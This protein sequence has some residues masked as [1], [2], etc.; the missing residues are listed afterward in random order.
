MTLDLPTLLIVAVFILAIAASLLL[1]TWLQN[2]SVRALALWATSFA[3][4]AIGVGLFV[5]RGRISDISSILIG[6]AFLAASYGVMWAGVRC[7]EGRNMSVPLALA[8][9]L[10]W[11][12]ACQFEAFYA[13]PKA[14]E[15]GRPARRERDA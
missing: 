12:L 4:A 1:V 15:T 2:P 14:R 10:V 3:L 11:L 8:G 9:A 13:S 6:H 7:F 5:A